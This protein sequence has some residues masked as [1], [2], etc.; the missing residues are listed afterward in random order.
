MTC[1]LRPMTARILYA[2]AVLAFLLA[3]CLSY[4]AAVCTM[5]CD[6]DAECVRECLE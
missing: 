5:A 3:H 6:D 1:C 2:A 4:P